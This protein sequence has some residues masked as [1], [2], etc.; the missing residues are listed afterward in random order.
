[1]Q[2]LL[3]NP[4]QAHA[5]H[6]A[7]SHGQQTP[8]SHHG[9]GAGPRASS[10]VPS[11]HTSTTLSWISFLWNPVPPPPVIPPAS[12]LPQER[13]RRASRRDNRH[14][15]GEQWHQRGYPLHL[16]HPVPL[17]FRPFHL[18]TLLF[19]GG[20]TSITTT[21]V[22]TESILSTSIMYVSQTSWA[23]P[24]RRGDQTYAHR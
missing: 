16:G 5:T 4:P 15:G 10:T 17:L 3:L 22:S 20:Q 11:S 9:S 13:C 6:C 19:L 14:K 12:R 7:S 23:P 21:R 18:G 24:L 8:R 2:A 1:M